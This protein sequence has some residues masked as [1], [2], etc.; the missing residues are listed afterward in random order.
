MSDNKILCEDE[1]NNN[2]NIEGEDE[3][4]V[5]DFVSI[6]IDMLK[7][8]WNL[9][10][11]VMIFISKFCCMVFNFLMGKIRESN[12][13]VKRELN[14]N[15]NSNNSNALF[16]K[17]LVENKMRYI[18]RNQD[19]S[20]IKDILGIDS[21]VV[22]KNNNKNTIFCENK[23]QRKNRIINRKPKKYANTDTDKICEIFNM[24]I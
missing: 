1:K 5:K 13:N 20:E 14:S 7:I 24:N 11:E 4:E 9:F 8:G 2:E 15:N 22:H 23:S 16:T 19:N 18:S 3:G 6:M 17:D 21:N 10:K 12:S